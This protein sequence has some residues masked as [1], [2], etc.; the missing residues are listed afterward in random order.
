[1]T[2]TAEAPAAAAA[3]PPGTARGSFA[4]KPHLRATDPVVAGLMDDE[5][6]R[7]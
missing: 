4:D 7:Q 1:V 5:L 3:L 2:E 6:R